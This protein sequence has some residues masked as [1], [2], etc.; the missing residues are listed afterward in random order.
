MTSIPKGLRAH[1]QGVTRWK[2]K[3]GDVTETS[4]DP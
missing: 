1:K 4:F 3:L 2:L